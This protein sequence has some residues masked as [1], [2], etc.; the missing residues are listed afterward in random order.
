[1]LSGNALTVASLL[2]YLADGNNAQ[3]VANVA[4]ASGAPEEEVASMLKHHTVGG[5]FHAAVTRDM[6]ATTVALREM[7][8]SVVLEGLED[9][10]VAMLGAHRARKSAWRENRAANLARHQQKVTTTGEE[11]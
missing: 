3:L 4:L 2:E 5:S 7:M 9:G 1:M 8:K 10:A 11:L 6:H